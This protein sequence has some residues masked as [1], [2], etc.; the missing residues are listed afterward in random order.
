MPLN[1][2]LSIKDVDNVFPNYVH[3]KTSFLIQQR[4][5]ALR[6]RRD[7]CLLALQPQ[8]AVFKFF[9]ALS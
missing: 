9:C 5:S 8:L 6:I 7:T 1:P 4:K 3:F 2:Q